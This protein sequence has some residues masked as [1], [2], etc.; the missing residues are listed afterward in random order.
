MYITI[1]IG[2]FLLFGLF[3]TVLKPKSLWLGWTLLWLIILI[4]SFVTNSLNDWN[5]EFERII[6]EPYGSFGNG[7]AMR[8]SP[9]AYWYKSIVDVM[10]A[11]RESAAWT[12]NHEQGMTGAECLA[13]CV[14]ISRDTKSKKEVHDFA[15]GYYDLKALGST[16]EIRK[17]YKFDATCEGS[18]PHAI[19]CFLESSS[20]E[21]AVRRAISLNG[22]AD[23]LAC[24][25]GA[26][27]EPY[28]GVPETI[29]NDIYDRL[30][31]LLREVTAKFL[32]KAAPDLL[33]GKWA[34]WT[35][36]KN[37]PLEEVFKKDGQLG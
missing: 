7:S 3:L 29:A 30:D 16:R 14:F 19:I 37:M 31:P 11:A 21:D 1:L 24:M 23:T 15:R 28:W 17:T 13:G 25:A 20:Y 12:H 22:D 6:K 34:E 4:S 36:E 35:E 18:V 27:A 32:K 2:F 26:I 9:I 10:S 33:V 5:S 8:V